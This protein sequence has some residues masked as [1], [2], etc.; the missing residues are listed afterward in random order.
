MPK[1]QVKVLKLKLADNLNRDRPQSFEKMPRMYLELIE[2]KEKIK[3]TLVN[4]E[5]S[6]TLSSP[7]S[8]KSLDSLIFLISANSS[9]IPV[10]IILSFFQ[11]LKYHFLNIYHHL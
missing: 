6:P 8:L 7:D 1:R 10:N 9:I 3:Q 2:N 5:Y 11:F 4:K